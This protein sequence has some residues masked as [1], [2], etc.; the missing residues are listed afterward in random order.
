VSGEVEI[1]ESAFTPIGAVAFL[2][3]SN[4]G[5]RVAADVEDGALKALADRREAEGSP[6]ELDGDARAKGIPQ[7]RL[8]TAGMVLPELASQRSFDQFPQGPMR[9][10]GLQVRH[11]GIDE[12][13][14]APRGADFVKAVKDL[15][16]PGLEW[17]EDH[18]GVHHFRGDFLHPSGAAAPEAVDDEGLAWVNGEADGS[19]EARTEERLHGIVQTMDKMEIWT[20][21]SVCHGWCKDEDLCSR[22]CVPWVAEETLIGKGGL[23]KP[24]RREA[25]RQGEEGELR[26][27]RLRQV[28]DGI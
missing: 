25:R 8:A 6:S 16:G 3:R 18:F 11:E 4:D 2:N 17:F 12:W 7:E 24:M 14:V 1:G 27:R 22:Q 10:A 13:V 15:A 9:G 19:V 21:G 5:A 20:P 26:V 23:S 28:I